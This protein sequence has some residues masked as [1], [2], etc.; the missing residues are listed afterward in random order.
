LVYKL[1]FLIED[2]IGIVVENPPLI[3]ERGARKE[4]LHLIYSIDSVA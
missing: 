4:S 1:Y 2:E 3:K